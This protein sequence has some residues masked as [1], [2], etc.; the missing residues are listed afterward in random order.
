MEYLNLES[1][2]GLNLYCYYN[3]SPIKVYQ[4]EFENA[5]KSNAIE[6]SVSLSNINN[7]INNDTSKNLS[8]RFYKGVPIIYFNSSFFNSFSFGAMFINKSEL[9]DANLL[10][11][12]W[13]HTRQFR[14][15]GIVGYFSMIAIP[16]VITNLISRTRPVDYYNMPWE[17]TSDIF[18]GVS[19]LNQTNFTKILGISYLLGAEFVSNA[20]VKSTLFPFCSSA[21]ASL[22][23]IIHRL[24][25][26]LLTIMYTS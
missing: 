13:G 18:C 8:Q 21:A 15:L 1:V 23:G 24:G 6:Y 20:I 9:G 12:E 5:L 19:R 22:D 14:L 17:I 11:H 7:N 25:T 3:N 26:I 16:S 2:N 10:P 4:S